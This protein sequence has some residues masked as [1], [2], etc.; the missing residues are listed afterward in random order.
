MPVID[1]AVE[2]ADYLEAQGYDNLLVDQIDDSPEYIALFNYKHGAPN[3]GL[4]YSFGQ[5]NRNIQLRVRRISREAAM[6]ACYEI[7]TK[8]CRSIEQDAI[9]LASG[10]V[11][12]TPKDTVYKL[13]QDERG[14][15]AACNI[16]FIVPI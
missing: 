14:T 15:V 1:L 3:S 12:G 6:Q 2:L 16:Q 5:E 11:V 7:R 9:A 8:L 4:P 13:E 10:R